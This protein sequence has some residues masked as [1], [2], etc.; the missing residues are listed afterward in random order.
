MKNKDFASSY[1][2]VEKKNSYSG[3]E[4]ENC[5]IYRIMCITGNKRKQHWKIGGKKT[6]RENEGKNMKLDFFLLSQINQIDCLIIF[7]Y[8][9]LFLC[10]IF[11]LSLGVKLLKNICMYVCWCNIFV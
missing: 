2:F 3:L 7:T 4:Y 5:V 6:Q 10:Y 1:L 9:S 11:V 8:F